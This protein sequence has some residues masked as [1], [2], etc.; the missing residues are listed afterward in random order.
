[1]P[2]VYAYLANTYTWESLN[3]VCESPIICFAKASEATRKALSLMDRSNEAIPFIK[4]GFLLNPFPLHWYYS[5]LGRAYADSGQYDK[6]IKA[7]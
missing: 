2:Q 1:M 7:L 5:T 6:A 4:K 3:G